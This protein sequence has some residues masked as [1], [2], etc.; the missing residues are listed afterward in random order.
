VG[1]N[2][3]FGARQRS[4]VASAW[5]DCTFSAPIARCYNKNMMANANPAIVVALFDEPASAVKAVDAL[6]DGGFEREQIGFLSRR[7]SGAASTSNEAQTARADSATAA[8]L[9]TGLAAGA[10]G[11]APV[12]PGTGPVFASGALGAALIAATAL[13]GGARAAL[14]GAGM[15]DDEARYYENE[16]DSDRSIVVVKTSDRATDAARILKEHGGV[17]RASAS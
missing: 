4:G 13:N 9:A 2:A 6:R 16:Y 8:I 14:M 15:S 7:A 3:T 17:G 12:M 5:G 11:A 10:I 1:S